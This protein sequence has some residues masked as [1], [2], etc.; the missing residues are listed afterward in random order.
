MLKVA[1]EN[2]N[3]DYAVRIHGDGA[4]FHPDATNDALDLINNEP[5]KPDLIL[6]SR[7]LK[8]KENMKMGYPLERMIPNF[9]IS[10]TERFY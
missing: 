8:F 7:F 6:G 5:A 10:R 3:A 2:F 1:F 9:F 4:Q